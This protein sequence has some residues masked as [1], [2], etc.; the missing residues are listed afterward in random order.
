M[1]LDISSAQDSVR[2]LISDLYSETSEKL[3]SEYPSTKN[4]PEKMKN[5][6]DWAMR[7]LNWEIS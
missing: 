1:E 7:N 2:S 5:Y 4:N 6:I 3:W